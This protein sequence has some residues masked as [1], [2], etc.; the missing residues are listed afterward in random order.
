MFNTQ[1]HKNGN[2][3][4]QQ[5]HHHGAFSIQQTFQCKFEK[6]MC[7]SRSADIAQRLCL[8]KSLGKA[9]VMTD[10]KQRHVMFIYD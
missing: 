7:L 3:D 10:K 9:H 5:A 8:I 2:A 1:Q 4:R 6:H